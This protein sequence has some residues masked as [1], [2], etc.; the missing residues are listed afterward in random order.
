MVRI[1]ETWVVISD[2][3]NFTLAKDRH[4]NDKRGD[5]I[6][7]PVGYYKSMDAALDA[8]ID[9]KDMQMVDSE[10][11]DLKEALQRMVGLRKEIRAMFYELMKGDR[12]G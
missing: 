1:D 8:Y 7:A 2:G 10:E 4:K 3:L 6:Y 5:P 9:R 11:L 12:N